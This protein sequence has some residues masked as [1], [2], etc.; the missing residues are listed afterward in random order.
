MSF[1]GVATGAPIGI[2][3]PRVCGLLFADI[4]A[5]ALDNLALPQATADLGAFPLQS[6][7]V[8]FG[9]AI[10]SLPPGILGR[11]DSIELGVPRNV[12]EPPTALLLLVGM[13]FVL[14]SGHRRLPGRA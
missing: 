9:S 3:E 7:G 5:V 6:W 4:A 14:S 13:L 12:A 1:L 2:R 10:G 11:I 8:S